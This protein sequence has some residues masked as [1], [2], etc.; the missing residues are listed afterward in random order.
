MY[1]EDVKTPLMLTDYAPPS[2]DEKNRKKKTTTV[3]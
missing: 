3:N 1:T 2:C